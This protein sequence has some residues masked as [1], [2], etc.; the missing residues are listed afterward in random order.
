MM[1]PK[2]GRPPKPD[3]MCQ[4]RVRDAQRK[5]LMAMRNTGEYVNDVLERVL[6][7][8]FAKRPKALKKMKKKLGM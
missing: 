5:A 3:S 8:Y 2:R 6:T 7:A 4:I 1:K